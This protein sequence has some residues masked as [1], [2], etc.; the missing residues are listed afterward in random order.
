MVPHPLSHRDVSETVK[1]SPL[2]S[3][4]LS[5]SSKVTSLLSPMSL[6]VW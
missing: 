6:W 3:A 1:L 4:L 5:F 2:K